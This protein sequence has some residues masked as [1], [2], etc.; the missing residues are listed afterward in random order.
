[1]TFGIFRGIRDMSSRV[2]ARFGPRCVIW[3]Y[4]R[5]A[6]SASDPYGLCVSPEHFEEQMQVIHDIATP[7]RLTEVVRRLRADDLPERA[8]C[9]TFDD[10]YQDNLYTAKPILERLDI[11]AT[12]FMTT[13]S[14][15]RQREFWW[16]EL[17]RIFFATDSL[18]DRMELEVSG[19]FIEMDLGYGQAS[20]EAPRPH[21]TWT[22]MEPDPPTARHAAFQVL[23]PILRLQSPETQTAALDRLLEWAGLER[24]V[25]ETHRALEPD[26]VCVLGDGRL[27]DIGGHTISHPDLPTVGERVRREEIRQCKNILAQWL[28]NSVRSFAY[29]YGSFS[30]STV[31]EV[32]QAGYDFACACMGQSVRRNSERFLLPRI[33][34]P[35]ESGEKFARK[36]EMYLAG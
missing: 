34:A 8:V 14:V 33:D 15:G 23:Y 18:P 10:G 32:S 3:L 17:E 29:P 21:R 11:P 13:G 35:N 28:G 9:V 31:A 27:I 5:V 19:Q 1:M 24:Y 6:D 2:K 20:M 4:H 25:R 36:L 12:V 7:M 30:E 26:E 16:D 22:V